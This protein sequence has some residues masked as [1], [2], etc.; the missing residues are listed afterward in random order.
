MGKGDHYTVAHSR[1]PKA[2]HAEEVKDG[3][4]SPTDS[5]AH[6]QVMRLRHPASSLNARNGKIMINSYLMHTIWGSHAR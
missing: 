4:F 1:L 3:F 2:T 5:G 6:M